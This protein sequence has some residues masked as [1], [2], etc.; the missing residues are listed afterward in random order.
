MFLQ[1]WDDKVYLYL[2][3]PAEDV[4]ALVDVTKPEKPILVNRS[5]VKGT[6]V[7]GYH[8]PGVPEYPP[9]HPSCAKS[10]GRPAAHAD[11]KLCG[12][13]QSQKSQDG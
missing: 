11:D 9:E 5:A 12:Y 1:Q 2:Y 4:Y 13:D 7:E 3:Q 6:G 10:G 8:V